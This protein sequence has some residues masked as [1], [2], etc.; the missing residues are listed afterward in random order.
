M[1]PARGIKA[2]VTTRLL[3]AQSVQPARNSGTARQVMRMITSAGEK[4]ME[5]KS[6]DPRDVVT[7][8]KAKSVR[9]YR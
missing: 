4:T 9:T 2:L 8:R 6:T 5:A 1:I 3:G 7:N